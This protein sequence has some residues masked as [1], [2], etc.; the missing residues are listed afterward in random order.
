MST[1]GMELLSG[2]SSLRVKAST[3]RNR[4]IPSL[5]MPSP[6]ALMDG[7]SSLL[8]A[9]EGMAPRRFPRGLQKWPPMK[10]PIIIAL[11][12]LWGLPARAADIA[13]ASCSQTD[14]QA[15]INSA[16]NGDI[17]LVPGPCTVAWGSTVTIPSTAGIT[18]KASGTVTLSQDGFQLN[19]GNFTSRIT[20][21]LFTNQANCGT[22]T[23]IQ[24]SIGAAPFR[25]D[26]NA[27]TTAASTAVLVCVS[28]IGPGLIDHN[29][30]TAGG[31]SEIIHLLGGANAFSI[32]VVPGGS[33]MT[34]I[35]DNTFTNNTGTIAAAEEAYNGAQFVFRH[36]TLTFAHNDIHNGGNSGRWAEIYGNTYNL[37]VNQAN[38][39]YFRGGSGLYWG[40]SVGIDAS[41]SPG[42]T[43]GPACPSSD[44]CAGPWPGTNQIGRGINQLYSPVYVWGNSS[45][46][47]ADIAKSNGNS[48][49]AVGTA[50]T[51]AANCSLHPGNVCDVVSTAAQPATLLRCEKATDGGTATSCPTSYNYVPYPYPHPLQGGSVPPPAAPTGLAAAVH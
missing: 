42:T 12:L 5:A 16:A 9:K 7:S 15:A 33:N 37:H 19:Q 24:V 20:G 17:V 29:A 22:G 4:S 27:F 38:F 43:F 35:E 25:I 13:A 3:E 48:L 23:P 34:F 26:H 2:Q 30:F 21:F 50:P 39:L 44:N 51:D 6:L 40:N 14:V 46:I 11:V 10:I 18:V 45:K 28:G 36:N 32:D 1:R 31:A 41:G 8:H 49:V 47:T